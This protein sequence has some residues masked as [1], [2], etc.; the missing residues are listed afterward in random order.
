MANRTVYDEHHEFYVQFA[1]RVSKSDT[2]QKSVATILNEL[3]SVEG[4]HVCDL[5]CGEGLLARVLASHGANVVGYDSSVELIN[6]AREKSDSAIQF[7][8]NDAQTLK[9][10]SRGTFDIVISYM[11][12]MDIPDIEAMFST[13]RRVL[14]DDGKFVLVLLHPC[15]E[16]PFSDGQEITESDDEGNFV[17]CRVMRYNEEGYWNSGGIG[18]RGRMGAFHRTISS[19]LNALMNTGLRL[20]KLMEPMLPVKDYEAFNDQWAMKIPTVL[21]VFATPT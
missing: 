6:H 15:F 19:Y 1:D 5:A 7:E 10:V 8:V 11:A 18:V 13:A 9:G 20:T 16:T 2:F 17:A 14:K 3:G 21:Y 4:L 12:A